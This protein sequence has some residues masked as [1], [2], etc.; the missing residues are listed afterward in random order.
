MSHKYSQD[1]DGPNATGPEQKTRS[2]K[3][4]SSSISNHVALSENQGKASGVHRRGSHDETTPA[5]RKFIV[6]VDSTLKALLAGEDTDG[7]L[8]ITVEDSGPKV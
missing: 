1:S 5:P 8:K 4:R 7:D 2:G 6:A 3:R